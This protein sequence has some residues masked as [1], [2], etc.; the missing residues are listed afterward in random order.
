[1]MYSITSTY[2]YTRDGGWTGYRHVPTF[3]LDAR[4]QGILNA[5]HAEQI[6]RSILDPFGAHGDKLVI[7]A[8]AV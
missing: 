6:A 2:V 8:F 1:M 5:D 3:Y 7:T 4:V